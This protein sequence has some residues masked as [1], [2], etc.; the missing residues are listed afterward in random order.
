MSKRRD[1]RPHLVAI[2]LITGVVGSCLHARRPPTVADRS[3]KI[4]RLKVTGY[5]KC[6]ECCGWKRNWFGRP[7]YASGK[8]KGKRKK[9]GQTASGSMAAFGTIAA[10]PAIPF[11]TVMHVPGYGYGT[12]EDRGSAITGPHIDLYFGSH[13]EAMDWGVRTL[14]VQVWL[15]RKGRK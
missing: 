12:V 7:V 2:F 14:R 13:R 4:V 11:G 9:V 10:D 8:L 3:G 15:P 1:I 6:A 5:C